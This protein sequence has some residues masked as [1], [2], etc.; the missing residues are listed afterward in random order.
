MVV[1]LVHFC[2][3]PC[4][5]PPQIIFSLNLPKKDSR[6]L[7]LRVFFSPAVQSQPLE[8][9]SYLLQKLQEG[10]ARNV[11]YPLAVSGQLST[12]NGP[13]RKPA[14]RQVSRFLL[15]NLCHQFPDLLF[16]VR[17]GG[18]AALSALGPSPA[19]ASEQGIGFGAAGF[20]VPFRPFAEG[21]LVHDSGPRLW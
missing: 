2:F 3:L 6:V 11:P 19:P 14:S 12:V 18:A 5:L 7:T 20:A 9:I 21:E 1:Q 15:F 8:I 16:P 10:I 13:W 17:S 4:F